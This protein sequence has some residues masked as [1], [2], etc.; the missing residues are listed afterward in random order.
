MPERPTFGQFLTSAREHARASAHRRG[1]F[2]GEGEVQE[3]I[4]SLL[5]VV[6]T[7]GRYVDDVAVPGEMR[8]KIGPP[9]T[10]WG[11]ARVDAREALSNA[12]V[13]LRQH[14]T[15]RRRPGVTA[16]SE[17]AWRLDAISASLTAG[18]DL[19]HTHLAL[20]PHGAR[21]FRSEWAPVVSFPPVEQALLAE[22]GGLAHQIVPPCTDLAIVP[23]ARDT[24][25]ARR[26][27][28]GASQWLWVLSASVRTARRREPVS[29]VDRELLHAI[30]VNAVPARHVP[31]GSESVAALYDIVITSAQRARHAAWAAGA[32]PAWSP[33]MTAD[34]MHRAAATSTV[35]SHHCEMLL[36]SLADRAA[37][38]DLGE[39]SV[40]LLRAAEAAGRARAGWLTIAHALNQVSTDTYRHLVPTPSEAS[41]LTLCTG[42]L[43]YDDP[44]WTLSS[45]PGYRSRSPQKLAPEPDDIP[46]AV[47]AVHYACDAVTGLAYAERERIR[48]AA[49]AGRLLVPTRSLPDTMDIPRPYAPALPD[50]IDELLS[51][52]QHTGME[53]AAATAE[54]G[55]AAAVVR[56]PSRVLVAAQT[57]RQAGRSGSSGRPQHATGE[58]SPASEPREL[59]PGRVKNVLHGLGIK[60]PDLLQRAAEID[61]ASEQLLTDAA[62]QRM[63]RHHRP[64][65]L[66]TRSRSAST[67]M[68]TDHVLASGGPRAATLRHHRASAELESPEAEP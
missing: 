3:V 32:Q 58:P 13:H 52:Y 29:A 37:D 14:G 39:L 62:E 36:R 42:R 25:D 9:L 61:R 65:R 6:I 64:P 11:R 19:L 45:G 17:L 57:A 18:R 53:A 44:G 63:L 30:P 10:A 12:A 56:A 24:A 16:R 68:L 34:S 20:D 28:N 5:H 31:G 50:R 54:V 33:R 47:S 26:S 66:A 51:L 22:L 1:V 8:Y 35:T 23:G 48:T 49:A 21:E 38:G 43:A 27:L 4:D 2:G 40:P 15:G 60:S 55:D 67:A 41:D 59:L 46:L 7:M